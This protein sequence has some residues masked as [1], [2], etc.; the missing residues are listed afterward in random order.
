MHLFRIVT[1]RDEITIGVPDGPGAPLDELAAELFTAGYLIVWQYAAQRG[2]DGIIRQA[3][4]RRIALAAAGVV[5][6]EPFATDQEIVAP[7][8]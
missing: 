3:P 6:I 7:A 8:G 4:L 1:S 2:E 5:R